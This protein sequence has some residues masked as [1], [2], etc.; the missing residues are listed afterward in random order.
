MSKDTLKK[1]EKYIY[2]LNV[3]NWINVTLN[4][5]NKIFGEENWVMVDNINE[6]VIKIKL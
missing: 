4:R 6:P 3:R 2:L 5:I 1:E